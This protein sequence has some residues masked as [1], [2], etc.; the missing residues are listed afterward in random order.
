MGHMKQLQQGVR[1]TSTKSRQGRPAALTQKS[2][3]D[4]AT[5]DKISA[6]P[7]EPGNSKTR[8]VF[9]SVEAPEWFVASDQT[10]K[11]PNTS[12]EG[13]KYICVFYIFDPNFI[14]GIPLKSKKRR[15]CYAPTKKYIHGVKAG[16]SNPNYTKWIVRHQE[17]SKTSLQA[18]K[19]AISKHLQT[20]TGKI[21]QKEPSKPTSHASSPP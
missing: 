5:M 10:G 18:N 19:Q 17:M 2:T 11:F 1:S 6:P 20:C 3:R 4:A 9:M 16:D 21:R 15:S 7:Q 12:K 14:K 13:M 8:L